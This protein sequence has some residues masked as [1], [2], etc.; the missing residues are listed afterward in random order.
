MTNHKIIIGDPAHP[1][2]E[3][4]NNSLRQVNVVLRNSYSGDELAYDQLSAASFAGEQYELISSE[5]DDLYSSQDYQLIS[6]P[7]DFTTEIPNEAVVRYYINN[8]LVGKFYAQTA[9]RENLLVFDLKAISA[10][11]LLSQRSHRGGIY[12]GET[13]A[14]VAADIIDGAIPFSC[15]A[16]VS[17]IK[18]F[19]WLPYTKDAREN[20]HQLLFAYGVMVFKDANGDVY[21]DYANT[22]LVK[23]IDPDDTYVNG[24]I[25]P[26]NPY[27]MVRIAEHQFFT[28]PTDIEYTLFDNTGGVVADRSLVLFDHAPIYDLTATGSL[29]IIESGV[30][31][32]IVSGYGILTGKAY[33]HTQQIHEEGD[34]SGNVL[35]FLEQTLVN[36][37]NSINVA[38][39]LLNY[40]GVTE[41]IST[42]IQTTDEKPGQLVKITN[43]YKVQQN[44]YIRE[45]TMT[46]LATVKARCDMLANFTPTEGGNNYEHSQILTGSGT[47]TVPAGVTKMRIIV[48]QGGQGGGYGT[49]GQGSQGE[50]PGEGGDAGVPGHAGKVYSLDINTAPGRTFAYSCGTGGTPGAS[51]GEEGAEGGETTFGIYSS[52]NGDIPTNGVINMLTGD[53]YA[54]PGAVGIPGAKGGEAGANEYGESATDG[55]T[56]WPGGV[57]CAYVEI[58]SYKYSYAGGGGAAYGNAGGDATSGEKAGDGGDADAPTEAAAL[59]SGGAAGHGGG[60]AGVGM[61]RNSGGS[62]IYWNSNQGIG[63]QPSAGLAGGDGFVCVLY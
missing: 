16:N 47:F 54:K 46:G 29:Q 12:N 31:H 60:G 57:G 23:T 40:Y 33:T 11:G 62:W 42:D 26:V 52:A 55:T 28:M 27:S 17:D 18:V 22:T 20:L 25:N 53:V 34:A 2:F 56:T 41:E 59:G 19:G 35:E 8:G 24:G 61:A 36:Q 1:D 5:G 63:G 9:E 6:A 45:M 50:N 13:F 3:L 58:G 37:L 15:S 14:E 39:R 32:A 30:N 48:V 49:A 43:P 4:D 21:F 7:A 51:A 44:A 10:I 38:E